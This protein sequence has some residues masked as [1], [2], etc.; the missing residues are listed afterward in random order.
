[1]QS[2]WS[3]LIIALSITFLSCRQQA[4]PDKEMRFRKEIIYEKFIGEGIAVADVNKDGKKDLLAGSFWFEAPHWQAH[5]MRE[6]HHFDHTKEWSDAFFSFSMDVDQ[7]GWMDWIRVGF[8]GK[9]VWWYRNPQAAEQHWEA[10]LIDSAVCNE[11]PL[12]VDV[13]ADGRQ[14]LVFGNEKTREMFWFQPPGKGSGTAWKKRAI[15]GPN[16]PGTKRFSHGLGL[17]D[18]NG[19]G[20][21][22]ILIRQGWWEAPEDREQQGWTFHA[23]D[24]GEPCSHMHVFDFDA[25]GDNDVFS[26]SAHAYGMWWHEQIPENGEMSFRRHLIDSSFSQTH[27]VDFADLNGDGQPELVTGKR[28]FAHNS[29]DPG[30]LE[31]AVLYWISFQAGENGGV[32]WELHKIDD[33]SGVGVDTVIED[34]NGDGKPDLVNANKKGVICFFQE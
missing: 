16:A 21:K 9:P 30:G 22:D 7:D 14:D 10:F 18:I 12:F 4:E 17:G 13:D 34:V 3:V 8:P 2:F 28:Y 29:K 25:D 23:V 5:E 1:M 11:S 15:S 19:D 33:D 27:A 32:D 26:A 20:R 31:P 6:P 24:W